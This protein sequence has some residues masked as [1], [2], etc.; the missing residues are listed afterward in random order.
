MKDVTK[1]VFIEIQKRRFFLSV[2]LA[3]IMALSNTP[4]TP[5]SLQNTLQ[6][7]KLTLTNIDKFY[8]T[9]TSSVTIV[10]GSFVMVLENN[11]FAITCP[12][13]V[14]QP[15]PC[16]NKESNKLPSYSNK[17]YKIQVVVKDQEK[18]ST[19]VSSG[20]YPNSANFLYDGCYNG[21]AV[22]NHTT[23]RIGNKLK[24]STPIFAIPS[25]NTFISIEYD[26]T[27][28]RQTVYSRPIAYFFNNYYKVSRIRPPTLS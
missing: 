10:D 13:S 1:Y 17:K 6:C 28:K 14:T 27:S 9:T 25:Q 3:P 12:D 21:L 11:S 2:F 22:V 7:G 16:Q 8:I 23:I 15:N 24:T 4:E 20:D 26:T 19:D 18:A 5:T